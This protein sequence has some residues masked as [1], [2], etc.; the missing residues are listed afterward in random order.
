MTPEELKEIEERCNKSTPRP[1]FVFSDDLIMRA[2]GVRG[3]FCR[4]HGLL[5]DH[6]LFEPVKAT[7]DDEIFVAFAQKDI[8]DLLTHIKELESRLPRWIPKKERLPEE[9]GYYL[10]WNIGAIESMIPYA[11]VY[12]FDKE[13]QD[14]EPDADLC[15]SHWQP[16]PKGPEE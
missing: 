14:F 7:R 15:I 6:K 11:D 12:Y 2:V 9:S 1:W 4:K 13:R 8:P 5:R 10:C 3:V 16:L